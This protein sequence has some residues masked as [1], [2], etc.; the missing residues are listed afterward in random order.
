MIPLLILR[1]FLV[2][3][4]MTGINRLMWWHFKLN[5]RKELFFNK[6]SKGSFVSSTTDDGDKQI[7]VVAFQ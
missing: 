1:F 5:S 4:Q 3:Q 7:G 2:I 6:A